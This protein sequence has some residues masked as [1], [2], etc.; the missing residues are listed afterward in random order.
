MA[1]FPMFIVDAFTARRFSGNPA[2]VCPVDVFP[3]DAMMQSIAA[4]NNLAFSPP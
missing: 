4:E 2:A 1:R 3:S